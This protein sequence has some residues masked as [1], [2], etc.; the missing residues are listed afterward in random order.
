MNKEESKK[1]ILGIFS[2]VIPISI[3]VLATVYPQCAWQIVLSTIGFTIFICIF[4]YWWKNNIHSYRLKKFMREWAYSELSS[5]MDWNTT[6]VLE[7][8][9]DLHKMIQ[10]RLRI[11]VCYNNKQFVTCIDR[12]SDLNKQKYWVRTLFWAKNVID[13]KTGK[14]IKKTKGIWDDTESEEIT[15]QV[16]FRKIKNKEFKLTKNGVRAVASY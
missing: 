5:A 2:G 15:H 6:S 7:K 3:T 9:L 14:P 13:K 12:D 11:V 8:Y 16:L 10:N 1:Y 4:V